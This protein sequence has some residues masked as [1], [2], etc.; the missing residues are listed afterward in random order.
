MKFLLAAIA[1][2]F[3]SRAP[4][5]N[6]G[7]VNSLYN[8][9]GSLIVEPAISIDRAD[10]QIIQSVS[11]TLFKV[12]KSAEHYRPSCEGLPIYDIQVLFILNFQSDTTVCTPKVIMPEMLTG[13]TQS[14]IYKNQKLFENIGKV[15]KGSYPAGKNVTLILPF[16]YRTIV[17]PNIE[18]RYYDNTYCGMDSLDMNDGYIRVNLSIKNGPT[19]DN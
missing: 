13:H 12:I 5:Q 15:I 14:L 6:K 1:L 19:D 11:D 9:D 16:Y 7:F 10:F 17:E 3:F 2:L 18:D 4:A 8:E